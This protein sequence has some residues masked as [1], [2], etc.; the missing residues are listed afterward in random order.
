MRPDESNVPPHC[1][2]IHVTVPG[3]VQAKKMKEKFAEKA[4]LLKADL[5]LHKGLEEHFSS[6][7]G[8]SAE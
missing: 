2:T 3:F 6:M 1:F 7:F 4:K 5:A 8:T